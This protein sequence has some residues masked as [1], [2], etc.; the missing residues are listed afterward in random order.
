VKEYERRIHYYHYVMN[1]DTYLALMQSSKDFKEVTK[2]ADSIF[3]KDKPKFP[4]VMIERMKLLLKKEEMIQ[5]WNFYYR[6][7]GKMMTFE[8]YFTMLHALSLYQGILK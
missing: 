3:Y 1:D 5:F 8:V 4:I 7:Y 6:N 2:Y